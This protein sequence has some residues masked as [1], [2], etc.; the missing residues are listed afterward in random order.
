MPERRSRELAA[1]YWVSEAQLRWGRPKKSQAEVVARAAF[2]K[3]MMRMT[4]AFEARA[5]ALSGTAA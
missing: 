2:E 1:I 5:A 3:A 4:E